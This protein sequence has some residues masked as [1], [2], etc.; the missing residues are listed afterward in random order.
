MTA[1]ADV[2]NGCFE[3]AGSIAAWRGVQ[4]LYKD[5][6]WAGTRLEVN[7]FFLLWG[8]WNLYY[9]P[10]LSQWRSFAGGI[11]LVIANIVTVSLMFKYRRNK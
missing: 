3:A 7:L 9:Y 2:I 8:L 11:S 1:L 6:R 10:S 5:K 4:A